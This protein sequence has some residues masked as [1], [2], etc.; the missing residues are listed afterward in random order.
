MIGVAFNGDEE[1]VKSNQHV[2]QWDTG[3]K[4]MVSGLGNSAINKVHFSFKGLTTAYVVDTTNISGTITVDVP[5]IVLRY[6]KDIYMYLCIKNTTGILT[7]KTVIIP[8]IKR[9]MPENYMYND[10]E[11]VET[12]IELFKTNAD[13]ITNNNLTT[14][15]NKTSEA[16]ESIEVKGTQTLESI[17]DDYS[18]IANEV[19]GART[20]ASGSTYINLKDR[21]DNMEL[22]RLEISE[23]SPFENKIFS[24][25]SNPTIKNSN[26]RITNVYPIVFNCN[27]TVKPKPGIKIIVWKAEN[28][29]I[30]LL[31]KYAAGTMLPGNCEIYANTPVYITVAYDSN[32][33]ISANDVDDMLSIVVTD[34]QRLVSDSDLVYR[35]TDLY[36]DLSDLGVFSNYYYGYDTSRNAVIKHATLRIMNVFPFKVKSDIII[37]PNMGYEMIVWDKNVDN[38]ISINENYPDEVMNG[39][40]FIMK[41][42]KSYFIVIRFIGNKTITIDDANKAVTIKSLNGNR[43]QKADF[44]LKENACLDFDKSNITFSNKAWIAVDNKWIDRT[45]IITTD[46]MIYADRDITV[47]PARNLN[48]RILI[49]TANEYGD[50]T[51]YTDWIADEVII[52]KH[53]YF[54]IE[55]SYKNRNDISPSDAFKRINIYYSETLQKDIGV[56]SKKIASVRPVKTKDYLLTDDVISDG[57]FI[58]KS[59]TSGR[60]IEVKNPYNMQFANQYMG[61]LHCHS[62][63]FGTT[64]EHTKENAVNLYNMYKALGYDFMTITNYPYYDDLTPCPV[65]DG[66]MVWLCNSFE[67][68]ITPT[69]DDDNQNTHLICLNAKEAYKPEM[70]TDETVNSVIEHLDGEGTTVVLAHPMWYAESS[71]PPS[72]VQLQTLYTKQ[73][74]LNL[75]DKI[76]FVEIFNSLSVSKITSPY[77][78]NTAYALDVLASSGKT[79]YGFAVSDSHVFSGEPDYTMFGGNIKVF[80]NERSRSAIWSSIMEGNFYSCESIY[81]KLNSIKLTDN[82]LIIDIGKDA[83]TKFYIKDGV[84]A[85]T[86]IGSIASYKIKGTESYVRAEIVLSDGKRMWT[87]PI[88]INLV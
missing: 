48:A 39:N 83:T 66:N 33:E 59:D 3:Q 64:T 12:S 63:T 67:Q 15:R 85:D 13:A 88:Y 2:Y 16:L 70:I 10:D 5:D 25:V 7:I 30:V 36:V 37:S 38:S 45:D 8:V 76:K 29:S 62:W 32:T 34:N 81:S 61:Q 50:V 87:N 86:V 4:V 68:G 43:I 19:I 17:P 18:A 58:N 56:I 49:L 47:S 79:V 44:K 57:F 69:V 6:G 46:Y 42:N 9:N 35:Y 73:Q 26:L 11:T 82:T 31:D 71:Y 1:R 23:I 27:V 54:F 77:T 28:S 24:G 60:I 55:V 72:N 52:P 14:I 21:L 20:N 22:N 84:V 51:E 78:N 74:L 75:S 40:D 80:A 41:S 53:T 65:P